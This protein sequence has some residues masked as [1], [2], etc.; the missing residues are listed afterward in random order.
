MGRLYGVGYGMVWVFICTV[1]RHY[2]LTNGHKN[3]AKRAFLDALLRN[4]YA[5]EAIE[6]LVLLNVE[7]SEH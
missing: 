2:Y 4:I 6:K 1:H 7:R 5:M 3:E